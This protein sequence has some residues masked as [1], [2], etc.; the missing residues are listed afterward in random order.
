MRFVFL[1]LETL[2][3]GP[4]PAIV[5]V[6]AVVADTENILDQRSILVD[7]GADLENGG[8]LDPDTLRWWMQQPEEIRA[9][10]CNPKREGLDV[11]LHAVRRLCRNWDCIEDRPLTYW[12][13]GCDWMWFEAGL[14]RNKMKTWWP[15]NAVRDLR[16]L[17]KTV[18]ARI[19]VERTGKHDALADA[20]WGARLL[21][22]MQRQKGG[23]L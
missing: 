21:Q 8:G 11:A 16:T 18:C 6:G 2:G 19:E 22:E 13:V 3:T 15:Y 14:R 20:L 17:R 10:F 23:L 5:Q 1:D 4:S 9:S 7:W 12:S